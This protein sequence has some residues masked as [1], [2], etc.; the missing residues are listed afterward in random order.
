MNKPTPTQ[1]ILLGFFLI[2]IAVSWGRVLRADNGLQTRTTTLDGVPMRFLVPDSAETVPGIIVAHG[3]AGSQQLM[4]GYGYTLA[5]A[6]YGVVLLDFT[7]HGANPAPLNSSRNALQENLDEAYA[8]LVSQP[9]VDSSRVGLVGH[10]M[11]S[12][13]VMQAGIADPERYAAVVAL[14]PTGAD[15]T[16]NEPRNLYLQAGALEGQFVANAKDLFVVA[17]GENGDFDG[18]KARAFDIIPNV[19]HISILFSLESHHKTLAW[20]D[21]VFGRETGAP[22]RDARILWYGLNLLGWLGVA[23]VG[24]RLFPAKPVIIPEP[25]PLARRLGGLVVAPLVTTGLLFIL[26]QGFDIRSLGGMLVGGVLILWFFVMGILWLGV[27]FRFPSVARRDILAG[28]GVFALLTL[29]FGALAHLVWLPWW[30]IPA[31]LA[32]VPFFF[33]ACLPWALATGLTQAGTS[34]RDRALWW[35]A[36]SIFVGVGLGIAAFAVPGMF[37]LALILPVVPIVLAVMSVAD[38]AFRSPVGYAMGGG[39]FF[40]WLVAVLFPLA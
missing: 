22:Y 23:L 11:G 13:A 37:F 7:G 21:Q 3:F 2:L 33:L 19:E 30:M 10:S 8:W 17:G 16:P 38:A 20:M 35:L 36:Q 28:V 34:G 18:G 15:V 26:A 31:R 9:E 24:A 40:A 1:T 5:H 6:G 32:R 29:A 14:S 4:L 12:G 25:K 39:L 27:G